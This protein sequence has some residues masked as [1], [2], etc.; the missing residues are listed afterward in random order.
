M[1]KTAIY[2]LVAPAHYFRLNGYRHQI[3]KFDGSNRE[4]FECNTGET[5]SVT[6]DDWIALCDES[7]ITE[8]FSLHAEQA[9][10]RNIARPWDT[11]TDA[12]RLSAL[13][14]HPFHMAMDDLRAKPWERVDS[15]L[16]EELVDRVCQ[17]GPTLAPVSVATFR[18]WDIRW[19]NS[20]RDVRALANLD[21][22][23]G[24]RS[25]I[26]EE[27]WING[28]IDAAIKE[29]ML[30]S[31]RL[32]A[33]QLT[34]RLQTKL[35][36]KAADEGLALPSGAR[37]DRAIGHFRVQRR[38]HEL[39]FRERKVA[40]SGLK[41]AKRLSAGVAIGPV[42]ERPL[43]ESESDHSMLDIIL[44]DDEGNELGRAWLTTIFDRSTRH[45]TGFY[46]TF[47]PPSWA[48]LLQALLVSLRAKKPMMD[49]IDYPFVNTLNCYGVSTRMFVDRGSDFIGNELAAFG[50]LIGCRI[51]PL[52]KASGA[53]K[54]KVERNYGTINGQFMS[55]LPGYV[56]SRPDKIVREEFFPRMT[57]PQLNRLFWIWWVDKYQTTEIAGVGKPK[58]LWEEKLTPGFRRMQTSEDLLGPIE[59][60]LHTRMLRET[61]VRLD[62]FFYLSD[63]LRMLLHRLGETQQVIVRPD[64]HDGNIL[65][66]FDAENR[67]F[68]QGFLQGPYAGLTLTRAELI[69]RYK[70]DNAPTQSQEELLLE[71]RGKNRFYDEID[72]LTERHKQTLPDLSMPAQKASEHVEREIYNPEASAAR[73]GSHDET[74]KIEPNSHDARGSHHSA[75]AYQQVQDGRMKLTPIP[76]KSAPTAPEGASPHVPARPVPPIADADDEGDDDVQG[77]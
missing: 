46:I 56:G 1:S 21:F 54:G 68:V 39:N 18:K 51:S 55:E 71:A 20:G 14:R 60:P 66:V 65:H 7:R 64:V 27:K 61:G 6:H 22:K 25:E 69:A 73:L 52:P 77:W 12:E 76:G 57:L 28:D 26:E 40:E 38:V 63:D 58:L 16:I 62:N 59:S 5:F 50:M 15:R 29:Y 47:E 9:I 17:N 24:N 37:E 72:L 31:P 2:N 23:K 33:R 8:D 53:K 43:M 30:K 74:Q 75:S 13:N 4:V 36:E 41:E 67:V 44:V 42:P 45:I 34:A 48:S 32:S 11:F 3:L 10:E 35:L 70:R 49:R 19:I